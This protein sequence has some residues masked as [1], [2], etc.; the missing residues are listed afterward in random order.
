MLLGGVAGALTV[1][2]QGLTVATIG[3]ALFTVGVVAGQ[4]VNGLVLDRVG[5]GPAGVVAVTMGRVSGAALV[6][7][8][9]VLCV[10]GEGLGVGAVVDAAAAVPRGRGHRLAAGD[11]RPAAPGGRQPPVATL[12]NFVVGAVVLG[13]ATAVH[14]IVDGPPPR[15]PTDPWLY[16]G[17]V[18]G[19]VYIFLSA[20]LVRHT[21]VLLLGLG[22]VVG[23]LA[24]SVAARR[25][26]AAAVGT[27]AGRGARR[28]GR[29]LRRC[30]RR[31]HPVA[32]APRRRLR[33]EREHRR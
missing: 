8:A 32:A 30:R 23:L 2:T 7:L 1:A 3:V 28:R 27:V 31:G 24:T 25:G 22:S 6:L 20:A 26:V 17:G 12:V 13:V 14:V 10:A 4:T 11:E 9:V 21:G 18:I 29:R 16:L 33:L 19:V 5:Y 15:V